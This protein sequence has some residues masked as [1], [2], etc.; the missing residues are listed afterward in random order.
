MYILFYTSFITENMCLIDAGKLNLCTVIDLSLKCKE[1]RG[2]ATILKSRL[3]KKI[4]YKSFCLALHF[5]AILLNL[6]L[7]T[8]T[9]PI[10]LDLPCS[11]A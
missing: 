3:K 7:P 8:K 10:C 6:E 4:A 9:Q 5:S 2:V 1:G 11:I